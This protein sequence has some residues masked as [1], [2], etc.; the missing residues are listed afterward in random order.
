MFDF[1]QAVITALCRSFDQNGDGQIDAEELKAALNEARA[2]GDE[3]TDDE[4]N[5]LL[6]EVDAD[7]S[8]TISYKELLKRLGYDIDD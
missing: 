7:G 8:G 2:K 4:A 6:A 3:M 1:S 5:R